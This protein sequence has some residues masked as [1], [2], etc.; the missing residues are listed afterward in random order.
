[1]SQLK[2]RDGLLL[3]PEQEKLIKQVSYNVAGSGTR[4]QFRTRQPLGYF[5][6]SDSDQLSKVI[7]C[8]CRTAICHNY[9]HDDRK[10]KVGWKFEYPKKRHIKEWA[11]LEKALKEK[12]RTHP[13]VDR[14]GAIDPDEPE[15][16]LFPWAQIYKETVVRDKKPRHKTV[17]FNRLGT[18]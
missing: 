11:K 6:R 2:L 3:N 17:Y 16:V 13:M 12:D 15:T 14:S 7:C 8:Q 1:M 9:D 18:I 10:Y 5:K 4:I